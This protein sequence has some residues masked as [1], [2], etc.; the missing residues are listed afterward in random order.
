[1][2]CLASLGVQ[3]W[4][5]KRDYSASPQGWNLDEPGVREIGHWEVEVKKNVVVGQSL[6]I[7]AESGLKKIWHASARIAHSFLFHSS[8]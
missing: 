8:V 6:Y 5:K 4:V 2:T 7:F 1:M 3:R